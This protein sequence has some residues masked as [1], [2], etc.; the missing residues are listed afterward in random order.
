MQIIKM[1]LNVKPCLEAQLAGFLSRRT[2]CSQNRWHYIQN[3]MNITFYMYRTTASPSFCG[4]MEAALI[5][6]VTVS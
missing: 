5:A 1:F 3:G 4:C 6:K 2:T